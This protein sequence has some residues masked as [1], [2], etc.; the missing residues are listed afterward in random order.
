MPPAL[1]ELR[2]FAA[3]YTAAWCSQNSASVAAYYATNGSLSVNGSAPAVGRNAIT[4]V[5]QSFMSAFP[6]L[7]IVMD[8]L[9][10]E[11]DHPHYHWTLTGTNTGPGGAGH[12]VRISGFEIWQIGPDSLIA[13]SQ[14]RFD[15]AEY[16]RQL[17]QGV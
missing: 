16:Q 2:D 1:S 15:N 17:A 9:H 12:S 5:A 3:R 6:D 10:M 13:S 8:D 7:H 4:E 14:G 11:G